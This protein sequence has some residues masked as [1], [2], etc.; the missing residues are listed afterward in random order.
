MNNV[1]TLPTTL[2]HDSSYAKVVLE[3]GRPSTRTHRSASW[4]TP[5]ESAAYTASSPQHQKVHSIMSRLLGHFCHAFP[6]PTWRREEVPLSPAARTTTDSRKAASCSTQG[7]SCRIR[8]DKLDVLQQSAR[9]DIS[10][11]LQRALLPANIDKPIEEANGGRHVERKPL[12]KEEGS[13]QYCWRPALATTEG[14]PFSLFYYQ[15]PS[16]CL[17]APPSEEEDA[18]LYLAQPY[19]YD[20]GG[21]DHVDGND[22]SSSD[23]E[24]CQEDDW[25]RDFE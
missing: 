19:N 15:A 21:E 10:A 17:A 11:E 1:N 13:T 25:V 9:V 18:R 3:G 6:S 2:L 7:Q 23:T 20:E 8:G 5:A 12:H 16:S 4:P 22:E 14:V 24:W